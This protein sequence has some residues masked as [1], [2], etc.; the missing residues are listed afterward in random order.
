MKNLCVFCGSSN[1]AHPKYLALAQ[2]LGE[3][4]AKQN[5]GLVYG[6]AAIGLMGRV[7]DAVLL[8]KGNVVGVIPQSLSQHEIIHQDLS[9]LF[10][11]SDMHERKKLMYERSDF[12]VA[13]PGGM[14]TLDEMC[15]ILTWAQLKYHNKPCYVLNTFGFYDSLLS[16]FEFI[17]K[18]GFLKKE[19]LDLVRVVNN[20]DELLSAISLP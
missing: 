16:H 3:K 6:G 11:V 14:G 10:V 4:M 1:G 19:H 12:F 7:A 17:H 8:Q 13:I 15:E 2:E 9:E 18:E 5:F 20:V